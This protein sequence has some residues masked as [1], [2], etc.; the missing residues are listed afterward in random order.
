[1]PKV[2]G[3]PSTPVLNRVFVYGI[4][5]DQQ[6]RD[7]FGM[8]N[9]RYETVDDYATFGRGIVQARYVPNVGLG[10]TGL[11]VDID[12]DY[13]DRLDRLE[14]GYDRK[15]IVTDSGDEAWM[16]VEKH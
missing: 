12:P 3:E 9:P 1:M 11:L 6:N 10:L 15:L 7:R 13:W 16:Y 14:A 8:S 5:L 2:I 4:F